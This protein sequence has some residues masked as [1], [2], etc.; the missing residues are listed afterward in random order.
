MLDRKEVSPAL[1]GFV[2]A[3]KQSKDQRRAERE[4]AEGH[5]GMGTARGPGHEMSSFSQP[6]WQGSSAFLPAE[7]SNFSAS[8]GALP[9]V[10]SSMSVTSS[11]TAD[12]RM[13]HR[14]PA[15]KAVHDARTR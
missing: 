7:D 4:A 14:S 12:K 8:G 2:Q 3:W 10:G 15:P 1:R 5:S 13:V 6:S 11:V 9:Q